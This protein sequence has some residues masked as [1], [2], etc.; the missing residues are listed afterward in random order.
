MPVGVQGSA[1][2]W[3]L[4]L[5]QALA[6]SAAPLMVFAGGL[7]GKQLH[8]DPG[9][10][11]LPIALMI[12][13]TAITALPASR[14]AQRLGR[15]RLFLLAAG[16]GGISS[17]VA[18]FTIAVGSFWG[19]S[20]SALTLG[21]VIAVMQ[22]SRFVAMDS[23]TAD[24]K[25]VAA[26][27]LLLGGLVS[28][29]LGPEL[30]SLSALWPDY[31]FASAFWGLAVLFIAVLAVFYWVLPPLHLPQRQAN[32]IGRPIA[33]I[34][35][36]PV[37][38]LAVAAGVGGYGLMAFIMTATPLSMTTLDNHSVME[39]KWVI[40]SHIAAMFL[41]SLISGQLVRYLGY[42]RMILLGVI[43][44]AGTLLVSGFDQTLVHYWVGLILLGLGWNLMFVAGTALLPLTYR[45]E[46]ASRVQGVNDMLVFTAQALGALASG[47]VLMYLGWQGLLFST[48]PALLLL[49]TL[50]IK[51]PANK[52]QQG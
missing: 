26:A 2:V 45:A 24:K 37:L 1:I 28:A 44:Y 43:V 4:M 6:L 39:A 29:F 11:T 32:N 30:T 8:T 52:L 9:F 48:I 27:R 12:V 47:T 10:A 38:W 25:P 7:I 31:G 34:F 23:V 14:L 50:L 13:G 46:E 21:G 35:S 51:V 3:W 42:H 17:L 41:P 49:L 36:Q 5:T 22:Q 18:G 16:M 33:E 20:L 40:Q 15:R 19:F